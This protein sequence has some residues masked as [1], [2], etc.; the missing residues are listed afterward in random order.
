[1]PFQQK[2]ATENIRHLFNIAVETW[3]K[4]AYKFDD[5]DIKKNT[6]CMSI[7]DYL[8]ILFAIRPGG[9]Q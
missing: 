2:I 5:N 6:T 3:L 4:I 8:V 7:K 1:M 9:F